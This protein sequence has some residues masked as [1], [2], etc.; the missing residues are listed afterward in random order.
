MIKTNPSGTKVSSE[1]AISNSS[2]K[3]I[4]RCPKCGCVYW[5]PADISS[6]FDP[7]INDT[8]CN[9]CGTVLELVP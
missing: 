4:Y 5:S 2:T 9:E 3:P 1:N 6:L 7:N 8:L